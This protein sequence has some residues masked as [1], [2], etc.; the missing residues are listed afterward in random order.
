M[1]AALV[2]RCGNLLSRV[3]FPTLPTLPLVSAVVD[4]DR[5]LYAYGGHTHPEGTRRTVQQ[6]N[7]VTIAKVSDYR[8]TL[9]CGQ[10]IGLRV[11]AA[12]G[13]FVVDADGQERCGISWLY[14]T[15]AALCVRIWTTGELAAA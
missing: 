14:A 13:M 12:A 10:Q 2:V 3:D 9:G 5:W 7:R 4:A 15:R 8:K 11:D 6:R 1:D